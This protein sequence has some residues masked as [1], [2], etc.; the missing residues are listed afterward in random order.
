[1]PKKIPKTAK[2]AADT[3]V[4][5]QTAVAFILHVT[6][7]FKWTAIS[8]MLVVI[9]ASLISQA[10]SYLFKLIIDA[11]EEGDAKK[12]LFFALAFPVFILVDQIFYRISGFLGGNWTTRTKKYANDILIEYLFKHSHRYFSDRFS[13]SLM[14]RV[15]NVVGGLES[16]IPDLLWTHTTAVVSFVFTA[17]FISKADITSG[18]IFVAL[19]IVLITINRLFAPK[20]KEISYKASELGTKLRGVII[21]ILSN[22]SATR[23][24]VRIDD[25]I[26]RVKN[27]SEAHRVMSQKSWYF[28]EYMLATN[29]LILFVFTVAIF[30]FLVERWKVGDIG[31]GD[32]VFL[33]ALYSQLTGTLLFIGRAFNNTARS[34]GEIDEGLLEIL[35]PYE[36]VDRGTRKLKVTGGEVAWSS[37]V[38]DYEK[39]R[40]FDD[41]NLTIKPGE[42]IGLVGSSGAGKTTFVSLMLRQ[43]ELLSGSIMI[44]GQDINEV[45][46]DSLREHIA[47]VPQEPMLF[48]RSIRENIAY[49]KPNATDKEITAVAK[50]AQAHDFINLLPQGS[51]T[52]VGERGV[53]LSGG[54][55]QRVAIARAML[56]NA[57]ILILDEA[58]SA[59]DSESEVAIQKA[60]HEL[61][62]GKTV[63]A[64][65]H[66]LSTLREMDRIIVLEKGKIVEDG[67]H[68]ALTKAGGT[69]ARLWEHQAGGFLTE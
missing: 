3:T 50:K 32:F 46:Q 26:K 18:M 10:G 8:A 23:Q 12:V 28:T 17:I 56:K 24:Y 45:T 21:D 67:T 57:P 64:I 65:A 63:V 13:G 42:R 15:G 38:F 2:K 51:D 37:V 61:M 69:Y 5:P 33:I 41:F 39:I 47:I 35:Q 29:V 48:H 55:R 1:M 40:V 30:Y 11:S 59:L 54:Q 36:I 62:V 31:T 14:S 9:I 44:D 58:T 25:E 22:I 52:L 27:A 43:H 6:K 20:K 49:G 53:K 34:F 7:A 68:Y 60:L 66:R 19:T 4:I 16:F